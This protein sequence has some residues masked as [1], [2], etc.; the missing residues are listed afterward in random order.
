MQGITISV[1]NRTYEKTELA[2]T[3]AKKE[4]EA[5]PASLARTCGI[6]GL[7]ER[8]HHRHCDTSR[9]VSAGL[10]KNLKGYKEL[11]EFVQSLQ[12]PRYSL[13]LS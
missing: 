11:K 8:R 4:G 2:V 12:K 1:F 10:D 6:L 13:A 9:L 5:S 3:R 7:I